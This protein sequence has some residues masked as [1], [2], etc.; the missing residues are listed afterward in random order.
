V[1]IRTITILSTLAAACLAI[2]LMP[3]PPNIEFTSLI[4][5]VTGAAFGGA[6]GAT[7]GILVM[8][9]NGFLSTYGFA[10]LLMPFQMLGMATIGLAGGVFRRISCKDNTLKWCMESAVLGASLTLLYDIT[11]NV[12]FA[13][14]FNIPII[15]SIIT[16]I[17]FS[18]THI[19]CNAIL[20]SILVTPLLKIIGEM[21]GGDG[22]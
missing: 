22:V 21:L 7:L 18:F 14:M 13:I 19:C 11:T 3:R 1:K 9:I 4:T 8:L 2:Q 15:V 17:V 10:S 5:F 12:G 16:G 20:F 6:A